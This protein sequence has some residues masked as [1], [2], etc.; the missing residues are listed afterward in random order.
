MSLFYAGLD[1]GQVND[2][3]AL[4][5]TEVIELPQPESARRRPVE[6]HVLGIQRLPLGLSYRAQVEQVADALRPF[7]P[8]THLIFDRTGVG[9]AVA[10]LLR[11]AHR[12]GLFARWPRG[13]AVTGGEGAS[14]TAVGKSELFRSLREMVMRRQLRYS[15]DAEGVEELIREAMAFE[16][17]LT[18]KRKFLTFGSTGSAHDDMLF[19]LALAVY[20]RFTSRR[21]GARYRAPTGQVYEGFNDAHARIGQMAVG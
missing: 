4:T 21:F 3:S 19:S 5:I 14:D 17:S 15:V 1:L 7:G 8:E 9:T 12:E 18:Q 11:D 10:D 2:P 16:P 6:R 13:V 20:P